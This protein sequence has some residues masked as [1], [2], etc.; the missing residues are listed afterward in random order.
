MAERPDETDPSEE[1]LG[2]DD[3]ARLRPGPER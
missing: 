2:E 1:I 3:R